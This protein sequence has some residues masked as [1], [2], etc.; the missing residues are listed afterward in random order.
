MR[1]IVGLLFLV[2]FT[3]TVSAQ[4]EKGTYLILKPSLNA[5]NAAFKTNGSTSNGTNRIGYGAGI[6][7]IQVLSKHFVIGAGAGLNSRGYKGVRALYL[8]VPLSV[9]Y[10]TKEMDL[11]FHNQR[12]LFGAGVY[13]GLAVM[14]KY[15]NS[16]GDWTSMK[17]GE[18][19]T[20]NR[21]RF[22]GGFL[23]NL[24]ATDEDLG[25][26]YL[27][28]MLGRKNVIPK[29]RIVNDNYIR[30]NTTTVSWALP[31]KRLVGKGK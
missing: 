14:G 3:I 31:L 27:S 13:G 22:D 2:L 1:K 18:R 21:S 23:F 29:D 30:L 4:N 11:L 20:D 25:A 15:K 28:F 17:F 5:G 7:L 19:S 26:L 12:I 8:D 9:N 24:G 10:L 16:A 6:E